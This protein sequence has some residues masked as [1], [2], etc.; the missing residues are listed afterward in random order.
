MKLQEVLKKNL[1]FYFSYGTMFIKKGCEKMALKFSFS[2]SDYHPYGLKNYSEAELRAEYS[3][4]R[5]IAKKRLERIIK[6]DLDIDNT[7]AYGLKQLVTLKDITSDRDLRSRLSNVYQLLTK[8]KTTVTG[9]REEIKRSVSNL[10]EAGFRGITTDNF[11][12]FIGYMDTVRGK[13]DELNISSPLAVEFFERM[14]SEDKTITDLEKGFYDWLL[15]NP[16]ENK[17]L[18]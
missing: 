15:K 9:R 5:S 18:L 14:N 12:K 16:F 6:S 8:R 3:R 7:Y 2:E 17:T 10:Q 13:L 11:K 4:L 1:I